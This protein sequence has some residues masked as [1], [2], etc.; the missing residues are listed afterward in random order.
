MIP[1]P[2]RSVR[3]APSR[4]IPTY[5]RILLRGQLTRGRLVG[6]AVLGGLS[7]LLA[8]VSR[9]APDAEQAG[10]DLLANYSIAL[11]I[12]LAALMLATPILGNLIEDRLLVYLWMKPTP[13]WHLAAAAFAA[14]TTAL[15][16]VVVVPIAL[17][18][19]VI[20]APSIIG[21]AVAAALLGVIA[22]GGLY[23]WIGARFNSGLWLGLLYLVLWENVMTR[24]GGF[25][26]V[27]IR[28]YLHSVLAQGTDERIPLADRA[29]WASIVVPLAVAFVC[30]AL[31]AATLQKRDVE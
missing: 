19:A 17:S 1:A 4:T 28:S 9:R 14:V 10:V 29:G 8:V 6:L 15:V 13:R 26:R 16:P 23:L 2:P 27:S 30:V 11:L 5:Y 12:P 24:F 31:T 18:A 3:L 7:V 25:A 20:G 22:Y 21:P